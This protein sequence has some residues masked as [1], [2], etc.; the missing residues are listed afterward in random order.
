MEIAYSII[1]ARNIW[2]MCPR[3]LIIPL[4]KMFDEVYFQYWQTDGNGEK[5]LFAGKSHIQIS[6]A[7]Y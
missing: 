7:E 4:E 3:E 1:T 5:M 6:V 2:F